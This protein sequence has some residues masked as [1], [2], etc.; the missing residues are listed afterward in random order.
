MLN[1]AFLI[2]ITAVVSLAL[3][4]NAHAAKIYK[5]TSPDG[6]V[7]YTDQPPTNVPEGTTVETIESAAK[8]TNTFATPAATTDTG[9]RQ[10]WIVDQPGTAPGVAAPP[11]D[12]QPSFSGYRQ[13][14]I[15]RPDNEE[16]IRS[17]PGNITI[18][19]T[20]YP[21]LQPGHTLQLLLDGN[22]YQSSTSTRI[23][24]QNVD[25]GT[26][27]AQLVVED[28]AGTPLITSDSVTFHVLRASVQR[29]TPR[30]GG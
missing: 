22:R 21:P 15:T 28:P 7:N 26:H 5:L 17:N 4:G 19:S 8:P 27:R 25:R 2:L 6:T 20:L 13:L 11:A 14:A 18:E 10:P 23:R 16:S 9:S 30:A 1:T 12:D 29:P 24:L 3:A